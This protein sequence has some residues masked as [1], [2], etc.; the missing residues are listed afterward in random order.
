MAMEPFT[1]TG[2]GSSGPVTMR[3]TRVLFSGTKVSFTQ[4]CVHFFPAEVRKPCQGASAASNGTLP[5]CAHTSQASSSRV[6]VPIAMSEYQVWSR[7]V[8]A[9]PLYTPCPLRTSILWDRAAMTTCPSC[10]RSEGF[11]I[12][13]PRLSPI[14]ESG[15]RVSSIRS[16]I[17]TI[18]GR[19]ELGSPAGVMALRLTRRIDKKRG[20]HQRPRGWLPHHFC[21]GRCTV[22][23]TTTAVEVRKSRKRNKLTSLP[24][25]QRL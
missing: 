20:T 4:S 12:L 10:T 15:K 25:G 7:T 1:A 22:C 14:V 24:S 9:E 21:T 18:A 3:R 13:A 5:L 2:F 11:M 6:A 19:S 17:R 23:T 16:S 8:T